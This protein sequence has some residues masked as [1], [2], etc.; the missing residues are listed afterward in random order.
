MASARGELRTP[1]TFFCCTLRIPRG[2]KGINQRGIG[3]NGIIGTSENYFYW[4]WFPSI[5][6]DEQVSMTGKLATQ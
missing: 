5:K 2:K 4:H 6:Q 1:S 3:V